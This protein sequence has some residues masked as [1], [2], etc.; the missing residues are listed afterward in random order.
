MK[1]NNTLNLELN[2]Y[3]SG[4]SGPVGFGGTAAKLLARFS[5]PK[6]KGVPTEVPPSTVPI[7]CSPKMEQPLPPSGFV[8]IPAGA[9]LVVVDTN[10]H[11]CSSS[12]DAYMW[13]WVGASRW[14]YVADFSI[15]AR[16]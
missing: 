3:A 11:P 5:M 6:P 8:D 16:T 15:P 2:G 9:T 10:M 14:F 4:A 7:P 13:T 1:N 12:E